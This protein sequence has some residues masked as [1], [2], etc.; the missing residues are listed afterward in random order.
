MSS[1]GHDLTH[2]NDVKPPNSPSAA[3]LYD[4]NN[5]NHLKSLHSVVFT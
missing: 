2:L 5:Y 4:L 3:G 1:I